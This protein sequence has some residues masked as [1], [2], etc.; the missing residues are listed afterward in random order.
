[1]CEDVQVT[2]NGIS[3]HWADGHKSTYPAS[4][5]YKAAYDPPIAPPVPE[6]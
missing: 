1:M 4:F 2:D 6:E 3:V 5:L